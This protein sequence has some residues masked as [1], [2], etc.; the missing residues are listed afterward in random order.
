M[1]VAFVLK[2]RSDFSSIY[3]LQNNIKL[4]PNN[5]KLG[6]ISHPLPLS[7]TTSVM[8]WFLIHLPS[9]EQ[10]Q[11]WS[12]LVYF[13]FLTS[14]KCGL[15]SHPLPLS[16]TS[17]NLVWFLIHFPSPEQYQTWSNFSSTSMLRNIIKLSLVSHLHPLS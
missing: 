3:P 8:V 5:I 12:N 13:F 15:I 11:T 9:P 10:Y 14:I 1:R 7:R 16:Q 17:S 6:L 4:V 2:S